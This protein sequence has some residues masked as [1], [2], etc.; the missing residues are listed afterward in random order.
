MVRFLGVWPRID[1]GMKMCL[2]FLNRRG[3]VC[4][5]GLLNR[6]LALGGS[7][8]G[9]DFKVPQDGCWGIGSGSVMEILL[10]A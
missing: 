2:F 7:G 5:L 4:L 3:R 1:P 10:K 6:G 9:V 8:E